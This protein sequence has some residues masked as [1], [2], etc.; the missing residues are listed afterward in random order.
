M[1]I[2]LGGEG[3]SP[4]FVFVFF[5][6]LSS[7]AEQSQF[8]YRYPLSCGGAP[9]PSINECRLGAQ[10]AKWRHP[11]EMEAQRSRGW[12]YTLTPQRLSF[13]KEDRR[14]QRMFHQVRITRMK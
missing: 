11:G 4:P 1:F 12:K 3:P 10:M 6:L 2:F 7:T 9:T 5:F 8:D 14:G 13:Q